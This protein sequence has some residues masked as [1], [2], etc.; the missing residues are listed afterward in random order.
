MTGGK[1]YTAK[2]GRKKEGRTLP[3]PGK[4]ELKLSEKC[5]WGKGNKTV[6]RKDA[7]SVLMGGGGKKNV[8]ATFLGEQF[9]GR[10][11]GN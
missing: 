5:L 8:P 1:I 10:K 3:P 11:R 9:L 6:G 4:R 7:N 2:I